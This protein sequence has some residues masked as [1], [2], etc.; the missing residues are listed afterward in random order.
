MYYVMYQWQIEGGGKR[1]TYAPQQNRFLK[2]VW[3]PLHKTYH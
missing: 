1:G 3:A 2:H